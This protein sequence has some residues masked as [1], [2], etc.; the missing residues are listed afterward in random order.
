MMNLQMDAH[1]VGLFGYIES[2]M[3]QLRTIRECLIFSAG[4]TVYIPPGIPYIKRSIKGS[5]KNW[6]IH[7]PKKYTEN[8]PDEIT[9]FGT[10]ELLL[11]VFRRVRVYDKT[12]AENSPYVRLLAVLID[13]ISCLKK[14]NH[15]HIPIPRATSLT[16]VA[17]EILKNPSDMQSID[18]WSSVAAMSRRSFTKHFKKETGL[19][20]SLWR[21]RVKLVAA[22]KMLEEKRTNTEIALTLGY[23]N[24]S[25]FN[26]LFSRQFG[27]SPG[28]YFLSRRS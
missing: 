21:Q 15:L 6:F 9:T 4:M 18:H 10:S 5:A 14:A 19:S 28:K 20:F 12:T 25:T 11:A 8:L 23:K 3:I 1:D 16:K 26:V 2:G 17:A 22:L 13:E 24:A 27:I 7:L